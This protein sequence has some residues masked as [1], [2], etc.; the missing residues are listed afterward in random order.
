MATGN[1][2]PRR[3]A[4]VL[5]VLLVA[6]VAGLSTPG[7]IAPRVAEAW[8]DFRP[9]LASGH[10]APAADFGPDPRLGW[11]L[12][13]QRPAFCPGSQPLPITAPAPQILLKGSQA[14]ALVNVPVLNVRG[15]P[16][17][18]YP[19]LGQ[20]HL[21]DVLQATGQVNGCAWIA[22]TTPTG[23]QGWVAGTNG[24]VTLDRPCQQLPILPITAPP[25]MSA[26]PI[27]G[28][29][30]KDDRLFG[31]GRLTIENGRD[32]DAVAVLARPDGSTLFAIYVRAGQSV[33][34]DRVADGIYSLYF[35]V[36]MDWDG[37]LA[38]FSHQLGFYR[39]EDT[40]QF[41]TNLMPDG[42]EYTAIHVTLH[43]I[44]NGNAPIRFLG[45]NEFPAL[46]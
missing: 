11:L 17:T 46:R 31:S 35:T 7:F 5:G 16:G 1:Q 27:S 24:Y 14:V 38:R 37:R 3:A 4:P 25:A 30:L 43:G 34:V 19:A 22:V 15:G 23:L 21:G 39:F 9:N 45:A 33:Q 36:G 8:L 41:S 44:V 40:L 26:R 28:A 29:F 32:T 10:P 2:R 20:V 18:G 12:T 13:C 6:L 42:I